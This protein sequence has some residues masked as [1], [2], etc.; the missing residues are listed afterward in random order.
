MV[1]CFRISGESGQSSVELQ[2]PGSYEPTFMDHYE[3]VQ[4]IE[5]RGF[6]KVK[7][8]HHFLTGAEVVVKVMAKLA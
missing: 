2:G 8:A 1:F 4:G 3:V 5:E 7:L 6:A